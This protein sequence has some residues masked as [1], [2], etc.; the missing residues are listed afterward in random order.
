MPCVTESY[1]QSG[2]LGTSQRS[3]GKDSTSQA[4]DSTGNGT[5]DQRYGI[6]DTLTSVANVNLDID[7]HVRKE[8]AVTVLNSDKNE[9][10]RRVL[11][12]VFLFSS[13]KDVGTVLPSS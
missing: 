1:S 7:G 4:I 5:A 9:I 6:T 10:S 3:Q 2:S 8:A 11:V 12:G 13:W